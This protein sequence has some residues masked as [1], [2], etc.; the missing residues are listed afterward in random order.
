MDPDSEIITDTAVSAANAGDASVA[1]ELIGDAT[2]EAEEQA[3]EAQA[4][5][6]EATAEAARA[7]QARAARPSMYA[8]LPT[9]RRVGPPGPG[10]H[11]RPLQTQPRT[12]AGGLFAKTGS[13]STSTTTPSP[14]S[15]R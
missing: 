4:V 15:T 11:R 14:V 7:S 6:D 3:L 2:E 1:P 13:S 10:R 8:T 5:E 9:A 12:A